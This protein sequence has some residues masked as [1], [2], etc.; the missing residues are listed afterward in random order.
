MTIAASLLTLSASRFPHMKSW[1]GPVLLTGQN[2]WK[3]S[4][5]FCRHY[6]LHWKC[7]HLPTFIFVLE[8][9]SGLGSQVFIKLAL[10][11]QSNFVFWRFVADS[12]DH[13][14]RK[15]FH[16]IIWKHNLEIVYNLS[17]VWKWF[18][19]GCWRL[20]NCC[21][22]LWN[23]AMTNVITVNNVNYTGDARDYGVIS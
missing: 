13:L 3:N 12:C 4:C 10:I 11:V 7:H 8:T 9:V 14:F 20:P 19:G 6:Y 21:V 2:E 5:H 15:R 1:L 16:E 23:S 22:L 17:L 18:S